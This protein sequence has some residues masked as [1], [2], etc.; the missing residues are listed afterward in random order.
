MKIVF[1]ALFTGIICVNL[2]SAQI[3]DTEHYIE[4]LKKP[5]DYL[6]TKETKRIGSKLKLQPSQLEKLQ[7]ANILY[8][9]EL[10]KI[11]NASIA[12]TMSNKRKILEWNFAEYKYL[13]Q[14]KDFLLPEQKK[15][16]DR[17][18]YTKQTHRLAKR[19]FTRSQLI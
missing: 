15:I 6:I 19:I 4:I 12:N 11:N 2:A 9:I 10:R 5:I 18:L 14:I 17:Q 3:N 1:L 8:Y 13:M 16:F 7:G